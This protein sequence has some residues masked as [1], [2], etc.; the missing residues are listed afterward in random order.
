[1]SKDKDK[2]HKSCN[3]SSS[4]TGKTGT[5]VDR[6]TNDDGAPMTESIGG[7]DWWV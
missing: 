6:W 5:W 4:S 7:C 2:K 3:S 1:M